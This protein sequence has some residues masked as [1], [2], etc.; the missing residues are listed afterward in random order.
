MTA[1]ETTPTRASR[2]IHRLA[3]P[4]LLF[5]V[6]LAALTNLTQPRLEVV[7]HEHNVTMSPSDAPSL[8]AMKRIG[9]VFGEFDSDSAAMIVLEG[10]EP[11]GDAARDYYRTLVRQLSAD[12]RHVQHV[13]DFWGDPLTAAGVQSSD[14][15]ATYL[16]VY[17]AGDQGQAL[18]SESVD[19]V[20]D[21][22][23]NLP[24]PEGLDV[25][26]TGPAPLLTDQFGV[27]T[28]G[29]VK[30]TLITLLVI[31]T[32][33]LIVYRSVG[34]VILVLLT[35]LLQLLAAR[36][37]IA[38]LADAGIIGLS[39]YATNL[40][41]L[42]VIAAGTDYSIFFL[43]RYQEARD[44]GQDRPAAFH[45]MYRGTAHVILGS[46]LTIAGAVACLNF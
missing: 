15:L 42:L 23:A 37:V 8:R 19:A 14:G 1:T 16:Q 45:T 36:G 28:K 11:L 32:M 46:G 21:L 35:V 10:G 34:T 25:Y 12:T 9:E 18:S 3:V 5:W 39:V 44:A 41:T 38:L 24:A 7:A 4:I 26:V 29:T 27:G 33:L 6:A 43:G 13:Q 31:A 30:V 2:A 40:L 17:L 20:R 22:V